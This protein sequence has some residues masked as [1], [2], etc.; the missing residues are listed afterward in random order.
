ML[1]RY[2]NEDVQ[3]IGCPLSSILRGSRVL[4]D[5][6][7]VFLMLILSPNN[8]SFYANQMFYSAYGVLYMRIMQGR[9]RRQCP[10]S[11]KE[12]SI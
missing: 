12:G 7:S 5:K 1:P 10:L 8:S 9:K 4:R 11:W 3:M 6:S 2:V